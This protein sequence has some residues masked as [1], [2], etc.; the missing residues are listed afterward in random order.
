[1]ATK[2]TGLKILIPLLVLLF[3]AILAELAL[4]AFNRPAA[5]WTPEKQLALVAEGDRR[6]PP[7]APLFAT[8]DQS[9]PRLPHKNVPFFG[10]EIRD[11]PTTLEKPAGTLRILGLGDS[12]AWGW[13]VLDNRRTFFKLLE[14]WLGQESPQKA[15]EVIN[16][17][18]PGAPASYYPEFLDSLGFRLQPDLVVV[19]FN[20]NDAY[21][22]HASITVDSRS[23]RQLQQTAGFWSRHSRLVAF[24]RER[25]MRARVRQDF[26]A[27]VREAYRGR[28]QGKRWERA[29]LDL[30]RV[31]DGCRRRGI[32]LLVVV[33]PLLVDL[34]R[35]YPFQ[36]EVALIVDFCKQRDIPCLDLL[37]AFL[38]KA[39]ELLWTHPSNAHPN[40][41]AH[42]LAAEAIYPTLRRTRTLTSR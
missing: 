41:V 40:E 1:M 10:A 21:V 2:N 3:Q 29:R 39:P 31:A 35:K 37:P 8:R 17:A 36:N 34:E 33:F 38:G 23:A 19:S 16:A 27:N 4:R 15:V 22:K 20:L 12:F 24:I 18:M 42:R 13:G 26:I 30:M 11:Y 25:V 9:R 5:P 14:H 7:S 28:D 6:Y 32:D